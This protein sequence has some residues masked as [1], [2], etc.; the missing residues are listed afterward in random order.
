[1]ARATVQVD[2]RTLSVAMDDARPPAIETWGL[3]RL[4]VVDEITGE[5]PRDLSLRTDAPRVL[6]RVAEGGLCGLVGRPGDRAAL[7]LTPGALRATVEAPGYLPRRLDDAIDRER[8]GLTATANGG[9]DSVVV[10]RP[11]PM[12]AAGDVGSRAQ[13]RPGRGVLIERAAATDADSF[14]QVRDL[15]TLPAAIDVPLTPP[16]T[17]ARPLRLPAWRLAGVPIV[18]PEQGLH[19]AQP[20]QVQGRALRQTAP[21]A[22]TVAADSTR[23]RIGIS[24]LWWTHA[25]VRALSN[26]PH[27]PDLLSL[28]APLAQDHVAGATMERCTATVVGVDRAVVRPAA[29]GDRML[30]VHPWTGLNPLGGDWLWLEH[31]GSGERELL[32]TAPFR[33]PAE[34]SVPA[35]VPLTTP[36]LF[37][38]ADLAL[39]RVVTLAPTAIPAL[40]RDAQAGDRVL[41]AA[42]SLAALPTE[43][44]LRVAGGTPREEL[45][46]ARC[47]PSYDPVAATFQHPLAL[48]ADGRFALPPLGRLSRIRVHAE[49]DLQAALPPIDLALDPTADT[50]LPILFTP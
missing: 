40:D 13:F 42:A 26:P 6:P 39:L 7:L 5:P 43:L 31:A 23:C 22:G 33:A 17:D 38:H 10:A 46:F 9:D 25:E 34:V 1:M 27:A 8:R 32:R 29:R 15:P 12:T 24:G 47:L 35:L 50:V 44:L 30:A 20:M 28:T 21:G 16:L 41:F 19:R 48:G 11:D 45:R 37:A 3:L 18:L 14:A 49:H 36:C 2:G 4:R